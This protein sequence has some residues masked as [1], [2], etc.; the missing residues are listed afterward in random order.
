M[1]VVFLSLAT[2]YYVAYQRSHYIAIY[3]YTLAAGCYPLSVK[4]DDFVLHALLWTF[5]SIG[6]LVLHV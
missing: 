2:H 3:L 4:Y 6:N 1:A 5:G